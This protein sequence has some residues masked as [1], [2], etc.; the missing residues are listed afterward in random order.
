KRNDSKKN[1]LKKIVNEKL[2][3]FIPS[4]STKISA[5]PVTETIKSYFFINIFKKP[6]DKTCAII[7]L[8]KS[9]F[10]FVRKEMILLIK[11]TPV[12]K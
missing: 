2:N 10:K 3:K 12:K 8:D 1:S 4:I 7:S 5:I 11:K 9:P 6:G